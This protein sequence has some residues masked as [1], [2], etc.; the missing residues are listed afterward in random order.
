MFS[1]FMV[2]IWQAG[3]LPTDNELDY[4]APKNQD[5]QGLSI[6]CRIIRLFNL[7]SSQCCSLNCNNSK[8]YDNDF[9]NSWLF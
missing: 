6:S 4:E 2:W 7:Y 5:I 9:Y 8:V 1:M 3:M